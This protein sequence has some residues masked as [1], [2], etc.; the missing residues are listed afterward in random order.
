M[1]FW[2][3]LGV[4]KFFFEVFLRILRGFS[5]FFEDIFGFLDFLK[6][7]EFWKNFMD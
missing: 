4:L 7:F 5:G 2:G 3:F 1:G 6:I